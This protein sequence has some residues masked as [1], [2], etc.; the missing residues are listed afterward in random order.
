MLVSFLTLLLLKLMLC[1]QVQDKSWHIHI[2]LLFVIVVICSIL[3]ALSVATFIAGYKLLRYKPLIKRD[4]RTIQRFVSKYYYEYINEVLGNL[5]TI[6]ISGIDGSGKS[7]QARLVKKLL[8]KKCIKTQIFWLRWN[9]FLSYCLYLYARI[10]KRTVRIRINGKD[11]K[12]HVFYVDEPLRKF[13]PILQ[14]IDFLLKYFLLT[15]YAKIRRARVVIFDRFIL[16]LV[17]DLIW[18]VR[19]PSFLRNRFLVALMNKMLRE[20]AT[21]VLLA[22]IPVI[23]SRKKDF[24]SIKELLFKRRV[25][26]IFAKKLDVRIIDTS[27]KTVISTF[28][29]LLQHLQIPYEML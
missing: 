8:E 15:L 21:I 4:I 3:A 7:T 10:L 19:D 27:E 24:H 20:H 13:Y 6:I 1:V 18:D 11:L 9:S 2:L 29:E 12:V 16:D 14:L 17:V 22:D 25:F 26:E 23:I 28:K 5:N